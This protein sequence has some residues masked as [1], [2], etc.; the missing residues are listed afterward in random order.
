MTH[1]DTR[2]AP[3]SEK[4]TGKSASIELKISE[5]YEQYVSLIYNYLLSRVQNSAIA[6]DLTSQTFLSA[7][8]NRSSVKDP[9]KVR[10]W[11]FTIA[12]NKANDHFRRAKRYPEQAFEEEV[13]HLIAPGS[14]S[15]AEQDE[16]ISLRRLVRQ[17]PPLEQQIIHLRLSSGLTFPDIARVIGTSENR[18]KKIYYKVIERLK[19]QIE[20]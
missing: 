8:E 4:S 10:P 9:E 15:S 3:T 13:D 20:D 16:L 1:L 12:R 7:V 11:L 17:L 2:R 19:A 5:L 14:A 6:E 18:I